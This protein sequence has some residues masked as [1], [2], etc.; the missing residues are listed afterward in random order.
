MFR[1]TSPASYIAFTLAHGTAP[2]PPPN[3][4]PHTHTRERTHLNSI[5]NPPV[6]KFESFSC[7]TVKHDRLRWVANLWCKHQPTYPISVG[8]WATSDTPLAAAA[9]AASLREPA[10]LSKQ[11]LWR[12]DGSTRW[13][14]FRNDV[15]FGAGLRQLLHVMLSHLVSSQRPKFDE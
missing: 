1:K 8:G 11:Q 13:D 2:T 6:F 7:E 3:T 14:A 5:N 12:P 10:M 15:M 9:A 4:H